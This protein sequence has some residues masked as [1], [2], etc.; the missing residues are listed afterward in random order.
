MADSLASGT[1]DAPT[2]GK[3]GVQARRSSIALWPLVARAYPFREGGDDAMF[4][5]RLQKFRFAQN[6]RCTC[7]ASFRC[8]RGKPNGYALLSYLTDPFVEPAAMRHFS[9]RWEC[10]QM[11]QTFLDLGFGVDVIDWFDRRFVPKRL[12][13]SD[14]YRLQLA[15]TCSAG[16]RELHEAHA[17]HG[18]ALDVSE[19]RR[20]ATAPRIARAL[21]VSC[22]A[23]QAS[24][25]WLR[26]GIGRLHYCAR[27]PNDGRHV[28]LCRQTGLSDTAFL[29]G[30]I[31]VER[32]QGFSSRARRFMWL[33]SSGMV[34][35]GLDLVLEAFADMPEL[36]L[37]V[38]GPA[39]GESDFENLYR[40]ELYDTP[41]LHAWLDRCHIAAVR[42]DHRWCVCDGLSVVLRG[43]AG[44]VIVG[45]HAG[46]I[47]IISRETGVDV[48]DFGVELASCTVDE[49]RLAARAHAKRG[50]AE[51]G[52]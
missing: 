4:K 7:L 29:R 43:S 13:L 28:R 15:A 14:R 34:H 3:P 52:N 33:G 39:S 21:A 38:C 41:H 11:A 35:K 18:Q 30:R 24:A 27:Q 42:L 2:D 47:P 8:G 51:L 37:V 50:A 20:V 9:N 45:L 26:G 44:S 12:S 23:A 6:V 40:R 19:F 46:L 1:H 17:C 48:Q 5:S 32:Q 49:I 22:S 16:G 25:D 31:S 10:R 36:E